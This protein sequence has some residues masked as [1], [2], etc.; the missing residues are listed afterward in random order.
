MA[1]GESMQPGNYQTGN[2]GAMP[3]NLAP[4]RPSANGRNWGNQ[5]M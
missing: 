3:A 2:V 5:P 1:L 4:A